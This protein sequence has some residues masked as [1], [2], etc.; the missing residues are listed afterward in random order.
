MRPGAANEVWSKDFFIRPRCIGSIDQVSGDRRRCDTRRRGDR[1]RT[2]HGW[3]SSDSGLVGRG[4]FSPRPAAGDPDGRWSGIYRKG[5]ADMVA[6]SRCGSAPDRARQA[7]PE[8]V[9]RILQWPTARRMSQRA[10]VHQPCTCPHRHRDLAPRI[11][12]G[13]TQTRT[14]DKATAMPGKV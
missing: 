8:R 14:G 10:L 13:G 5:D 11:Q 4:M 3:S 1:S 7:E 9:R 2:L 6:S 12:Q